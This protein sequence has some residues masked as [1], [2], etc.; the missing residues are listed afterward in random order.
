M[1]GL[2]TAVWNLWL[3]LRPALNFELDLRPVLNLWQD[4]QTVQLL[5][6]EVNDGLLKANDCKMLVNDF[7]MSVWSYTQ[8]TITD[9]HFT[10]INKLSP[11]IATFY[12]PYLEVNHHS[13]IW[14][15]LRSCIDWLATSLK[16]VTGIETNLK[17]VNGLKSSLKLV[18]GLETMSL[19]FVTKLE[20]S[21]KLMTKVQSKTYEWTWNQS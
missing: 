16:L 15:S 1:I 3:D 2:E 10:I 4:L 12:H 5:N 20:T 13:L 19:K 9:E 21:L 7:E 11:S 17:L 8:F 18:T 14:P 6:D